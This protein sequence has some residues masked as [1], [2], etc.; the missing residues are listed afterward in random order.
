MTSFLVANRGKVSYWE[1]PQTTARR[2]PTDMTLHSSSSVLPL[3]QISIVVVA[4]TDP[5]D[6]GALLPLTQQPRQPLPVTTD[7][8]SSY[9]HTLLI[10]TLA[11]HEMVSAAYN[12]RNGNLLSAL[13][14]QW[15]SASTS[16][17]SAEGSTRAPLLLV[18][19][20]RRKREYQFHPT[21]QVAYNKRAIDSSKQ[22]GPTRRRISISVKRTRGE[23]R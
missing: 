15:C 4:Y 17:D 2:P 23:N 6:S 18:E 19:D 13:L 22:L 8:G 10:D 20:L 21:V 7:K 11:E 12:S 9:P 3:T 5:E 16:A 1:I 14:A